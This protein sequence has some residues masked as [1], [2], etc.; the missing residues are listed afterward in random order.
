MWHFWVIAIHHLNMKTLSICMLAQEQPVF[1]QFFKICGKMFIKISWGRKHSEWKGYK[2]IGLFEIKVPTFSISCLHGRCT[3]EL[4]KKEQKCSCCPGT[5]IQMLAGL[6]CCPTAAP[7]LVHRSEQ[8]L[9]RVTQ[10]HTDVS[11]TWYHLKRL[12]LFSFALAQPLSNPINV[13]Q[14]Q[15]TKQRCWV[16]EATE[17]L[18]SPDDCADQTSS[19]YGAPFMCP[20][21][22]LCA[23]PRTNREVSCLKEWCHWLKLTFFCYHPQISRVLIK[24]E[25]LIVLYKILP[26]TI[27]PKS[28][29]H[30]F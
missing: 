22:H 7:P 20:Q 28:P 6:S 5:T 11:D 25:F 10:H 8:V 30:C 15:L 13:V 24:N 2:M 19:G 26:E 29:L 4:P 16:L 9:Y 17:S 21:R 18:C 14:I 12:L 27:K 1:L 23:S 3:S